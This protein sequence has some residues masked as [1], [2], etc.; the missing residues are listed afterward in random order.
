MLSVILYGCAI[1]AFLAVL[2]EQHWRISKAKSTLFFGCLAWIA[3]YADAEDWQRGEVD[4]AFRANIL[5]IATLWLFLMSTMT[6]VAYINRRG[7]LDAFMRWLLPARISVKGLFYTITFLAFGLSLFCDNVTTALVATSL[8]QPLELDARKRLAFAAATVFA[9]TAGG[10]ALITGDVTTLMIFLAGKVRIANLALLGVAALLALGVLALLLGRGMK[11]DLELAAVYRRWFKPDL[12]DTVIAVLFP[13]TVVATMLLNAYFAM[14]PVLV[15]LFGLSIMLIVGSY[16]RR[17]HVLHM[18]DY[19]R[20][21][22]FDSLLFFLGVLLLVGMLARVE[23]LSG[24]AGLYQV[25][26]AP[27]CNYVIGLLSA[28]IG[29]VPLTAAVLKAG[30]EMPEDQWM[31]LT[32]SVVMG[33]TL[34]ATGSAA[35]IIAMGKIRGLTLMAYARYFAHLLLAYSVGYGA[36]VLLGPRA[37]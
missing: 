14:P 17:D 37:G 18:L 4:A 8:V 9:V 35:G 36:V 20:E 34:L 21:I 16:R 32:Y 26:P 23:V 27:L 33:G 10:V 7:L 11:G 15:F 31:Q 25:L 1:L 5:E 24:L 13:A 12:V 30:I 2:L 28:I 29:N 19:V 22:E 6:F 3:M